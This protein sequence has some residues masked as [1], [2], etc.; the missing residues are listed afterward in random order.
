M[1]HERELLNETQRESLREC[2]KLHGE[3]ET[4]RRMEQMMLETLESKRTEEF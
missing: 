2:L 3:E 4:Q 1:R